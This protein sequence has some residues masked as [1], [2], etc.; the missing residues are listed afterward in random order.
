MKHNAEALSEV[1]TKTLLILL[2]ISINLFRIVI[3]V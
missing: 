1:D 3:F 2:S